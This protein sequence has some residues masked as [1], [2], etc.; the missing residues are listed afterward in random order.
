[1]F[2]GFGRTVFYGEYNCT[3]P[4]ASTNNRVNYAKMLTEKQAK[5]FISPNFINAEKWLLPPPLI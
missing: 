5:L 2:L 3:G 4:G 1:M